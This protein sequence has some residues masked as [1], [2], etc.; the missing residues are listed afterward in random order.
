MDESEADVEPAG[1]AAGVR[2]GE[3]VRGLIEAEQ[4]EELID[5]ARQAATREPEKAALEQEVL[6]TGCLR[7]DAGALGDHADLASDACR[8]AGDIPAGDDRRSAVCA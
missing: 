3:P 2:A 4:G 8:C 7:I 6:A 1:H 5:P